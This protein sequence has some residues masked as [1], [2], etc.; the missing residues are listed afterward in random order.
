MRRAKTLVCFYILFIPVILVA[1]DATNFTQF[2]INPYTFNPSYAGIEGRSAVFLSYRRQWADIEGGPAIANLSF[3][4]PLKGGLNFGLS[5]TDDTRGILRASGL[6]LTIGY[7]VTIDHEKF[8]RFGLSGGGAW[9]GVDLEAFNELP[10]QDD[11]VLLG[12]L[13]KNFSL[14]GNAGISVHLKSFHFGASLPNIFEPLFVSPDAF[15]LTEL[16]P[17]QYMI[18]HASNR[19]YFSGDK[20]VFE[21]YAVYRLGSGPGENQELKPQFEFAGVLHLNH[22]VWL[23]GSYK[24]DFGISALGGIKNKYFLIG[25]SYSLKNSGVNELN[26]PTYE[27][28]LGY[29]FGPQR[30]NKPPVYSFVNS[31]KE[32]IKKP[33]QKTPAQLAAEKKKEEELAKQKAEEEAKARAEEEARQQTER[34]AQQ[35]AAEAAALQQAQQQRE[36]R[37]EEVPS[38]L[39]GARSNFGVHD[40]GPRFANRSLLPVAIDAE[41][42]QF[43]QLRLVASNP[44]EP[45]DNDPNTNPNADRHEIVKRGSHE[46]ELA[47]GNYVVVGMFSYKENVY[48]YIRALEGFGFSGKFG[49]SSKNGQWYVYMDQTA[50]INAAKQSRDRFR[51]LKIFKDAWLLTVEN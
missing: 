18:F 41:D 13:E 12:L 40:G 44:R 19:F 2:F 47:L 42:H 15:K 35:R 48:R 8:I 10:D 11:P 31:E 32:K 45:I 24:Q 39:P 33:P 16:K 50:D 36:T 23:G 30:K 26:S 4:T 1:Q 14:I 27:I 22:T 49:H 28:H 3:H 37:N 29:V 21:P 43:D 46:E 51:N 25:G 6:L 20:H 5:V 34:E 7:T 17:F 38:V 9:N